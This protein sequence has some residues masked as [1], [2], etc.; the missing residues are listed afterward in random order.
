MKTRIYAT[1]AVKGLKRHNQAKI[2]IFISA[3][4]YVLHMSP[5]AHL[6]VKSEA[7]NQNKKD[8]FLMI[9]AWQSHFNH[10]INYCITIYLGLFMTY[11]SALSC[12]ISSQI[13]AE[14]HTVILVYKPAA[15]LYDCE[16]FWS[17]YW[18]VHSFIEAGTESE[19]IVI[20]PN[21]DTQC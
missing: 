10:G 17:L 7:R 12:M 14:Q 8:D 13:C 2:I 19:K 20:I 1:P 11:A 16:I 9:L 4:R 18:D 6:P 21:V 3:P 15:K 5:Y